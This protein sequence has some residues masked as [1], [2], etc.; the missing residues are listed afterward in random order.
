MS[1]PELTFFVHLTATAAWRSMPRRN[2]RAEMA[3]QLTPLLARHPRVAIRWFDA[4][5]WSAR[6]SHVVVAHTAD[7]QA[8]TDFVQHARATTLWAVPYFEVEL[9]VPAV[10]DVF[11]E[12]GTGDA[13]ALDDHGVSDHNGKLG[14]PVHYRGRHGAPD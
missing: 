6:P 12:H 14:G 11:A 13:L 5:A 4:Q 8:W 10:E 7:P 9:I 2:Q 1:P 3:A